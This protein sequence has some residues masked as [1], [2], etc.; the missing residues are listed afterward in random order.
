ALT[1]AD[2]DL[3]AKIVREGIRY[4]QTLGFKP[5]P[6]YYE[7]AQFLSGADPDRRSERIP[8]GKDGKPFYV[9]GPDDHPDLILAKLTKAVGAGNFDYLVGVGGS[10]RVWS[11]SED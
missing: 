8:L 10:T 4:A 11:E 6:D 5:H 3:A 7:A 2:L 1:G 9:S